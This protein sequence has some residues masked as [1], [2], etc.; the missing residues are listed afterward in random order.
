MQKTLPSRV[1]DLLRELTTVPRAQRS[2]RLDSFGREARDLLRTVAGG[3]IEPDNH[4]VRLSALAA[5]EYDRSEPDLSIQVLRS[6]LAADPDPGARL[7]AMDSLLALGKAEDREAVRARL[8]D[9]KESPTIALAAARA[10][11]ATEGKAALAD[12]E[13]LRR[14]MQ[15]RLGG[16]SLPS[17][18]G[19]DRLIAHAQ[20]AGAARTQAARRIIVN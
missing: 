8:R 2:A 17:L 11:L 3:T 7:Q 5:I 20:A 15:A 19:L 12:V 6:V 18:R 14:R 10:L 4:T 13:E 1:I 9:S 16:R